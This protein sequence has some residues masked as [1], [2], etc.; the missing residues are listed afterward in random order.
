MLS[1]FNTLIRET[2]KILE[3]KIYKLKEYGGKFIH[4][5]YCNLKEILQF[6]QK[7]IYVFQT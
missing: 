3:K 1:D 7:E 5:W 4:I 2:E 6:I